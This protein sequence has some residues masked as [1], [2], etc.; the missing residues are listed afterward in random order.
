MNF[1]QRLEVLYNTDIVQT[2]VKKFFTPPAI[3]NK[4]FVYQ[5]NISR[6]Y[7]VWKS[8]DGKLGARVVISKTFLWQTLIGRAMNS[9]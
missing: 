5:T 1:I 6:E 8:S 7:D 2:V 4:T 9:F 3:T